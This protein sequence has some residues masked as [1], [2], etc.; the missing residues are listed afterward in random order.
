[1]VR[2]RCR[3][4]RAPATQLR[5]LL[6]AA[7]VPV[8][9]QALVHVLFLASLRGHV[10]RGPFVGSSQAFVD[11]RDW[12]G[13]REQVD[14]EAALGRLARRYLLGHGPADA[15]DLARWAG[16]PL[17]DARRG[18]RQ[19]DGLVEQDGLL[20]L[21]G[22]EPPPP[23]PGPRLLGPFDPLLLGWTSR[24]AVVGEHRTLVTDNGVFRPFALVQGRAVAT[25]RYARGRV[26]LEPLEELD[27]DVLTVLEQDAQDVERFLR[28]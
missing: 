7:A 28:S 9:G 17:G 2:A 4:A 23:L 3:T 5:D 12:L 11:A 24:D 19:V 20:D 14:R 18:L 22:R 25:W 27:A 16:L 6:A 1:M 15:A 10:L 13:P 8:A 21:P 26:G